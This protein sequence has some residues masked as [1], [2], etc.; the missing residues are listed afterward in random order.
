[1]ANMF[2]QVISKAQQK[3]DAVWRS[4][5]A[6]RYHAL[7]DSEQR[8]VRLAAIIIPLIIFVFGIVLPVLDTHAAL[9]KEVS[10]LSTKVSEA[11]QLADLLAQKPKTKALRN[12]NILSSVDNIARKTGVRSFMTRLR[13]Q[14]IP[15]NKKSLQAQIKDVPYNKVVAFI[16]A[17]EQ[18]GLSLS[19][20]KLQASKPG[21][22][23]MQATISQ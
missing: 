23:H 19:Q 11:N 9:K 4:S 13:P 3:L 22:V 16:A 7:N 5:L 1:M 21:I 6:P 2:E 12:G 17:L 14:Q 15:G 10:S 8:L 20:I 18:A